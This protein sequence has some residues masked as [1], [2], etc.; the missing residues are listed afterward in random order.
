MEPGKQHWET[1]KTVHVNWAEGQLLA[2]GKG[3]G[4]DGDKTRASS[5]VDKLGCDG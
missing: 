2:R 3:G 4:G 5:S 1:N